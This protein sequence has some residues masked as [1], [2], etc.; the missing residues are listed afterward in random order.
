MPLFDYVGHLSKD[1]INKQLSQVTAMLFTSTW[2]E[3]YG[4]TLAESLACGT[5]VIGFDVGASAE[6]I[7]HQTGI[8]VPKKDKKA[9]IQ[10][11]VDIQHISR[12]ACRA[13]AEQ[14]CSVAAMVD[15]Y[16]RLYEQAVAVDD[17]DSIQ[18]TP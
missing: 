18:D 12:A 13:R 9:F 4:L 2:N 10:A 6:I 5:P 15:G 17:S 1:Q 16:L 14:F 8:I 7:T 11:F 3:P